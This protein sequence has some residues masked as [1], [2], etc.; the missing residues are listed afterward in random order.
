LGVSFLF[1]FVALCGCSSKEAPPTPK[2]KLETESSSEVLNA[3]NGWMGR[4]AGQDEKLG[5]M[6]SAQE[7]W[8]HLRDMDLF[9]AM[10]D[11]EG[12]AEQGYRIGSAR[13][14]L[15]LMDFFKSLDS[16]SLDMEFRFLA[17]LGDGATPD[18]S[19]RRAFILLRKEDAAGAMAALATVGEE[20]NRYLSALG[21]FWAK[22]L[23][24]K[25]SAEK[26]PPDNLRPADENERLIGKIVCFLAKLPCAESKGDS[27]YD[28]A[29]SDL[30]EGRP[31]ASFLAM[32]M[33]DFSSDNGG[34]HPRLFNYPMLNRCL[35]EMTLDVLGTSGGTSDSGQT[36]FLA[37]R[38]H[39]Y[40]G[41]FLKA[42]ALYQQAGS[43]VWDAGDE[44]WVFSPYH[45]PEEASVLAGVYRGGALI[46]GGRKEEGLEVWKS[47]EPSALSGSLAVALAGLKAELNVPESADGGQSPTASLDEMRNAASMLSAGEEGEVLYLLY[48]ARIAAASRMAAKFFLLKGNPAKA[49]DVISQ[50]HYKTAGYKPSF[51]NTP[52][53][54]ADLARIYASAGQFAVAGAITFELEKSF[55]AARTAQDSLKRLYGQ[56]AGGEAPPR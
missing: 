14:Y 27:P 44:M 45:G 13:T 41:N 4:Y 22:T 56:R 28:L 7:G 33:L 21:N 25:S 15:E 16:F 10:E 23:E 52:A 3:R 43:A 54:M 32:Q 50:A 31:K 24:G 42:A 1:F 47:L 55:P 49:L 20:K 36:A 30:N 9:S 53:F 29:M 11:F 38:A 46:R 2:D 51:G 37:A 12:S 40:L 8:F 39:E 26:F 35:A 5:Q 6:L 17:S 19:L 18:Q 34:V 48:S